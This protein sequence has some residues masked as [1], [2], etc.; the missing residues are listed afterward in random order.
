MFQNREPNSRNPAPQ[1]V[2]SHSSAADYTNTR[3]AETFDE[4]LG[5]LKAVTQ[6]YKNPAWGPGGLKEAI[7]DKTFLENSVR[8]AKLADQFRDV[9]GKL[10]NLSKSDLRLSQ[11]ILL[12]RQ[13]ALSDSF[14][15]GLF[16]VSCFQKN[17]EALRQC[18]RLEE[19]LSRILKRSS[20]AIEKILDSKQEDDL[21]EKFETISSEVIDRDVEL[22]NI[23][24]IRVKSV[25]EYFPGLLEVMAAEALKQTHP[26]MKIVREW[27]QERASS[28]K[29]INS[30][31]ELLVKHES[32]A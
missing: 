9:I 22:L 27:L 17:T 20:G 6:E 10:E 16:A 2:T 7:Q 8:L 18:Q 30:I 24:S 31:Y 5:S 1:P 25:L 11:S 32:S 3:Q 14:M 26:F 28:R 21:L 15:V 13:T 4:F 29:A 19:S 12:L 23:S